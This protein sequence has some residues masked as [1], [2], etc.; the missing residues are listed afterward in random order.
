[1]DFLDDPLLK[2]QLLSPKNTAILTKLLTIEA[3]I[4]DSTSTSTQSKR[5][6]LKNPRLLAQSSNKTKFKNDDGTLE[7]TET[8]QDTQPPK[9]V[10]FL[11]ETSENPSRLTKGSSFITNRSFHSGKNSDILSPAST[12][13]NQPGSPVKK[14]TE[15][16]RQRTKK[17]TSKSRKDS[18]PSKTN[19]SIS[20][21]QY[22]FPYGEDTT[23]KEED[24]FSDPETVPLYTTIRRRSCCCSDCGD[25]SKLEK[26]H[27]NIAIPCKR[28]LASREILRL[29]LRHSGDWSFFLNGRPSADLS[30]VTRRTRFSHDGSPMLLSSPIVHSPASSVSSSKRLINVGGVSWERAPTVNL[31]KFADKKKKSITFH[32]EA[33][34]LKNLGKFESKDCLEEDDAEKE[35]EPEPLPSSKILRHTSTREAILNSKFSFDNNDL[36]LEKKPSSLAHLSV[37]EEKH[38]KSSRPGSKHAGVSSMESIEPSSLILHKAT[39][40]RPPQIQAT[41]EHP[42]H[43]PEL[44]S[45]AKSVVHHRPQNSLLT[46]SPRSPKLVSLDRFRTEISPTVKTPRKHKKSANKLQSMNLKIKTQS[47]LETYLTAVSSL[48]PSPKITAGSQKLNTHKHTRSVTTVQSAVLPMADKML[49]RPLRPKFSTAVTPSS[50]Q[51]FFFRGDSSSKNTEVLPNLTPRGVSE[52]SKYLTSQSKSQR[53]TMLLSPNLSKRRE[54]NPVVSSTLKLDSESPK[55]K[56]KVLKLKNRKNVPLLEGLRKMYLSPRVIHSSSVKS[57]EIMP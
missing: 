22:T 16:R 53:S 7:S 39:S 45:K 34:R 43:L 19:E 12:R 6:S 15:Y 54:T 38:G 37:K 17:E 42:E 13:K 21:N 10:N 44:L 55:K 20:K 49:P 33:E 25:F 11:K 32:S 31:S 35:E 8:Q 57:R 26:K 29:S 4:L 41:K 47:I 51:N 28:V 9:T 36:A 1:M 24:S 5:G 50:S 52:D 30:P 23:A 48:M 40:S 14:P 2:T 18:T 56:K 27:I 46:V 3:H